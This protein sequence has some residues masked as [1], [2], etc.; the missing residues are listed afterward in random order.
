M[1]NQEARNKRAFLLVLMKYLI[2]LL[3]SSI[4]ISCT[5]FRNSKNHDFYR[6]SE[7]D[8]AIS[9]TDG[10]VLSGYENPSAVDGRCRLAT[11]TCVNG[12]YIG[13]RLFPTCEPV[14]KDCGTLKNGQ[15]FKGFTSDKAPCVKAG[16]K[17]VDGLIEGPIKLYKSCR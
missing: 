1:N 8:G 14:F 3:S 10:K 9:C 4:L 13:P 15:T 16:H 6:S 17:C 12:T 5:Y 11:Q 7:T 2:L